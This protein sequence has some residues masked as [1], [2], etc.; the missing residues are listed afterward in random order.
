M[1]CIAAALVLL[2]M[3]LKEAGLEVPVV[4]LATAVLVVLQM[5][6]VLT[7]PAVVA[8]VAAE[9]LKVTIALIGMAV[10][11]VVVALEFWAK[12]QMV[13][14]APQELTER[15]LTVRAELVEVALVGLMG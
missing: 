4:M 1:E 13:L 10:V 12:A 6:Q 9:A 3:G 11:Q 8:V 5:P 15:H 7:A 2:V 14:A